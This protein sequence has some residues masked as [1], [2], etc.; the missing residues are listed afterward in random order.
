MPITT[1]FPATE[2]KWERKGVLQ[3]SIF[4]HFTTTEF[5]QAY[6]HEADGLGGTQYNTQGSQTHP[7]VIPRRSAALPPAKTKARYH[8]ATGPA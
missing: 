3:I 5:L 4:F 1:Y 6:F 2:N 8:Q 7:A